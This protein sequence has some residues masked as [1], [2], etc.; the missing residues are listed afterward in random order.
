MQFLQKYTLLKHFFILPSNTKNITF[1]LKNRLK[2][3]L[4]ANRML[5]GILLIGTEFLKIKVDHH[6]PILL[7]P[8]ILH[9]YSKHDCN[10][11]FLLTISPKSGIKCTKRYASTEINTGCS[12][13]RLRTQNSPFSKPIP[14]CDEGSKVTETF[15]EIFQITW[16]ISKG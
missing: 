5:I 9:Y 6:Y 16:P 8:S 7:F 14:C 11:N 12:P 3:S 1:V 13:W 10:T 2:T 4:L 15:A